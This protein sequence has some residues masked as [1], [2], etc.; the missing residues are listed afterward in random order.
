MGLTLVI[1]I[2][3]FD[4]PNEVKSLIAAA[5][6]MGLLLTPLTLGFFAWLHRPA[7]I[8]AS[9]LLF[10]AGLLMAAA[11]FAQNLN[12]Y[13]ILLILSAIFGVQA[14]PM[15]A[16][17]Y[18][19]NYPPNKRGS[20]FSISFMFLG[21][22]T[23]VSSLVFGKLLDMDASNYT[24]ILGTLGL[25]GIAMGI[26]VR[27]IP[28]SAIHKDSTQNPLKNLAYAFTDWKFGIMLLSYTFVG[29][30][31]LMIIPLR[32]E[33]LLKPEYGIAASVTMV[34]WLIL[35]L[36][37]IIRFVSAKFW[38]RLFDSVDFMILRMA[39]NAIQ[40][41]SI[42]IFF[43]TKNMWLLG[44]ST[45]LNG[46]AMGGGTLSWNLWVTKFATKERTAG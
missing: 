17:M 41:V 16:H 2:Q 14:L 44:F 24:L 4:A 19:E 13:L 45:A 11:A 5:N 18:A 7:N 43:S 46:F 30:G 36:P 40:M 20:Y 8:V 33:Y 3:V 23:L 42:V 25:A 32:I 29:L 38:G 26:S 1:A 12:A 39:I 6:P 31:N 22:A 28:S 10:V 35:G 37:A 15:M 21:T 27:R 34:S 9:N